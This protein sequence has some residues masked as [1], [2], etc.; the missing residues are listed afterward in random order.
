MTSTDQVV[1]HKD[2]LNHDTEFIVS[3]A[4]I[5]ENVAYHNFPQECAAGALSRRSMQYWRNVGHKCGMWTKEFKH[6][7][8]M[9]NETLR[10]TVETVF[11]CM[12]IASYFWVSLLWVHDCCILHLL[13]PVYL[14][15]FKWWCSSRQKETEYPTYRAGPASQGDCG[16][17]KVACALRVWNLAILLRVKYLGM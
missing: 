16:V 11:C 6:R 13:K 8:D 4:F 15:L 9:N 14:S 2:I 5:V 17:V 3:H 1:H 12:I 7:M 10:R